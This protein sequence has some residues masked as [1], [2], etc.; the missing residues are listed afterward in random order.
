MVLIM[1]PSSQKELPTLALEPIRK[2]NVF[3]ENVFKIFVG[4][5]SSRR[6]VVSKVSVDCHPSADC[7]SGDCQNTEVG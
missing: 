4:S 7:L 2:F 1:W 6:I 5:M 3:L